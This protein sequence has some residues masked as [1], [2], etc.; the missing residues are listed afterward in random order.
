VPI[1]YAEMD[2][3]GGTGGI[4]CEASGGSDADSQKLG[5]LKNH[6]KATATATHY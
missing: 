5:R 1:L 2:V 3:P 6:R 4:R